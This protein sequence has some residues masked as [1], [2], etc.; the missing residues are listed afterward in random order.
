MRRFL[1]RLYTGSGVLAALCVFGIC[2]LM[3][4]QALGLLVYVRNL[5]L[6][7]RVARRAAQPG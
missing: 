5:V 6:I 3:L 4:G 2:A 7:R 1:D